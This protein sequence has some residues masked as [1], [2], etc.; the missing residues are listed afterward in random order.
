[1]I[2]RKI[3]ISNDVKR[4]AEVAFGNTMKRFAPIYKTANGSQGRYERRVKLTMQTSDATLLQT[5]AD[6]LAEAIINSDPEIDM[7]LFGMKVEGLKKVYLS[8]S[9]K[10]AY[11]VTIKEHVYMP[12][13]SEKEVRKENCSVSN[14]AVDGMPIRWTGKW[15]PKEKIMRMFVFKRSYQIQHLNGLTFDFLYDMAKKLSE[16]NAM[17]LLGGGEKGIAPLIMSNGGTAYRAFLE[18]RVIG[19][20]YALIMRLTNLEIKSLNA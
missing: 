4:D 10:V 3:N 9:Q 12:D 7:E 1:M 16:A 19:N 18:G 13:G 14:I 5:Y 11:G 20:S 15:I 2:M 6:Q 17:M 8:P